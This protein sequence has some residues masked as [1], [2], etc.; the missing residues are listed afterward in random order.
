M[1]IS[2]SPKN[3]RTL[4]PPFTRNGLVAM[5]LAGFDHK[6]RFASPAEVGLTV[7]PC[8]A[9]HSNRRSQSLCFGLGRLAVRFLL[10]SMNSQL[11]AGATADSPIGQGAH[12][13]AL[14]LAHRG[15]SAGHRGRRVARVSPKR[16]QCSS[17]GIS[18]N[19][20]GR[21]W[22]CPANGNCLSPWQGRVPVCGGTR[23]ITS[24]VE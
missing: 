18:V 13:R 14:L 11:V 4:A 2:V 23:S 22:F 7:R 16:R 5:P 20:V 21:Q 17:Y 9:V 6:V 24:R 10:T 8:H 15:R 19:R 12:H 3:H 1:Y